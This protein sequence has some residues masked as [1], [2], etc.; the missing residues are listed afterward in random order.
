MFH[1]ILTW[2]DL[3]YIGVKKPIDPNLLPELPTGYPSKPRCFEA[4][5]G[6]PPILSTLE[7]G[8]WEVTSLNYI[9]IPTS[10]RLYTPG[11]L[12]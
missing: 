5:W 4:L 8:M 3:G 1:F 12:T 6:K 2:R 9:R 11:N 7:E 10:H